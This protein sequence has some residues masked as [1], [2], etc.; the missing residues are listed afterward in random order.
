MALDTPAV[1]YNPEALGLAEQRLKLSPGEL[2]AVDVEQLRIW[3]GDALADKGILA[4]SKALRP[5]PAPVP[6]LNVD[7]IADAVIGIIAANIK[8]LVAQIEA[9]QQRIAA[10]EARPTV[11]YCG[12][13]KEGTAYLEG[14][15]TTRSGGLWVA[16][17]ATTATP[18]T[19]DSGWLLAVKK[20]QAVER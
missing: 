4:R 11:K 5:A 10:L 14:A 15:M 13:Y 18:G 12:S 20:G 2:T 16:T 7:E 9:Q 3:G 8:P 1:T 6:R 19:D 17:R